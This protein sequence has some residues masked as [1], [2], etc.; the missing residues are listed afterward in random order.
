MDREGHATAGSTF[1]GRGGRYHC[2]R[3]LGSTLGAALGAT[4]EEVALKAPGDELVQ[5]PHL[6]S[7]R[8]V[9]VNASSERVWPWL[10]QIGRAGRLVQ[11]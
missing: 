3:A 10:V 5:S 4:D 2:L 11:L 7:T 9:R 6:V 8:A 1:G